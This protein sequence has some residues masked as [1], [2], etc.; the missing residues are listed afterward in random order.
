MMDKKLKSTTLKVGTIKKLKKPLKTKI[1]KDMDEFIDSD[2]SFISGDMNTEKG[3]TFVGINRPETSSEFEQNTAQGP[4]Y[5]FSPRYGA[6]KTFTRESIA[7]NKMKTMIED[8]I[9]GKSD[10]NGDIMVKDEHEN[11]VGSPIADIETLKSQKPIIVRKTKYLGEMIER[12]GL[13]NNEIA[14]VVNYI[15]SKID[16]SQLSLSNKINLIKKIKNG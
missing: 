12:E 16:P 11:L 13:N 4:R 3:E 7:E 2:G 15:L 10:Y 5:Y 14:I 6:S 9:K 1:S 8:I